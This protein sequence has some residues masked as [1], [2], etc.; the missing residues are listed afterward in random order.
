MGLSAIYI[1]TIHASCLSEISFTEHRD[2]KCL[3]VVLFDSV[4]RSQK[5]V[6]AYLTK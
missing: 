3:C 2:F 4:M 5:V 6:A 1:C